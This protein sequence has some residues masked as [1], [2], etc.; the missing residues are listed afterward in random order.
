MS[1]SVEYH[2]S[3]TPE[4]YESAPTPEGLTSEQYKVF[5]EEHVATED[6]YEEAIGA[7]KVWKAAKAKE[8]WLEK[9]KVDKEARAEKLKVLQKEEEEWKVAEEKK[10][11]EERQAVTRLARG[12]HETKC[13]LA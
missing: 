5:T 8:V 9:L 11:E 6:K 13:G 12:T 2:L 7:C 4:P 1:N 3:A 10:K